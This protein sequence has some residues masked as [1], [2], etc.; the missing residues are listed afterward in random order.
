M[1]DW[2][3]SRHVSPDMHQDVTKSTIFY[4]ELIRQP[5]FH[6]VL[7]KIWRRELRAWATL[8]SRSGV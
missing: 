8:K 3:V 1:G 6:H 4:G 2:R 5:N 7:G